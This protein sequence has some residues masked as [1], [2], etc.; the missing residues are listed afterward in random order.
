VNVDLSL[1]AEFD[2]FNCELLCALPALM[3]LSCAS[4]LDDEL[5]VAGVAVDAV[6]GDIVLALFVTDIEVTDAD[7]LWFL[8]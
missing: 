5:V 7:V 4:K 8:W 2:A 6:E 3:L 1:I